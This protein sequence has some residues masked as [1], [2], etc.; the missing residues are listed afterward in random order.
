MRQS[1][2]VGE[3]ARA[4]CSMMVAKRWGGETGFYQQRAGAVLEDA[5][6]GK[7]TPAQN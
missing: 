1:Q 3:A 5:S 6:L 7:L 4:V 2:P